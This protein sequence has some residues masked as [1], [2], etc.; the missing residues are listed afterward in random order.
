MVSKWQS[1]KI[2][3]KHHSEN[4]VK[5]G[6]FAAPLTFWHDLQAGQDMMLSG[7]GSNG[8][9]GSLWPWKPLIFIAEFKQKFALP[10]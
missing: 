1:S 5:M 4:L 10:P 8:L 2:P 9:V 7:T 6:F 3:G